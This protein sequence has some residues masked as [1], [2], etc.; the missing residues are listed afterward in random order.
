MEMLGLFEVKAFYVPA[1]KVRLLRPHDITEQFNDESISI[2]EEGLKLSGSES[3]EHR[4]P[5]V[6]SIS[7]SNNLPTTLTFNQYGLR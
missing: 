1:C 4:G 2:T 7:S 6:A 3:D 5:V